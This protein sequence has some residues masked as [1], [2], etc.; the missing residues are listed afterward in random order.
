MVT[1]AVVWTVSGCTERSSGR[2][3]SGFEESL[4]PPVAGPPEDSGGCADPGG[5]IEGPGWVDLVDSSIRDGGDVVTVRLEVAEAIP[6]TA[7]GLWSVVVGVSPPGFTAF[8]DAESVEGDWRYSVKLADGRGA[9][10]VSG[11]VNGPNVVVRIP[12]EVIGE[13]YASN[14]QAFAQSPARE[15]TD[16]F[17]QDVCPGGGGPA[18]D[19]L[20]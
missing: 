5:D 19:A 10:P 3:G 16:D 12:K 9:V 6:V 2:G 15:L 17:A 13:P 11:E 8:V 1:V 18:M 4:R 20:E 14:Y 7:S